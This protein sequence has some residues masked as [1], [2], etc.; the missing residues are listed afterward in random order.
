V[1]ERLTQQV[2]AIAAEA[3]RIAIDRWE[4]DFKRWEKEPGSPVCDIDLELDA[5][6]RDR[7]SALLPDAGGLSE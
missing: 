1:T 7:L 6:L 3:G 2:A 5:M 4:S